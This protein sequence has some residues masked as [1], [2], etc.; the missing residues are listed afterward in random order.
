MTTGVSI[1]GGS[2]L[3]ARG[4]GR[5]YQLLL[6]PDFVAA[7]GSQHQ[8]LN[9]VTPQ[10]DQP[11]T[12]LTYVDNRGQRL[13]VVYSS[14]TLV[15]A[16][17]AGPGTAHDEHGRPLVLVFGFVAE[18]EPIS[19][20]DDADL[21]RAW[22]EAIGVYRAFLADEARFT[23]V[24][25]ASRPLRSHGRPTTRPTPRP[26]VRPLWI[27]AGVPAVVVVVVIVVAA[28]A[29]LRPSGPTTVQVSDAGT[30]AYLTSAPCLSSE[31]ARIAD[32][33][34]QSVTVICQVK[35][36][37]VTDSPVAAAADPRGTTKPVS[38]T[39]WYGVNWAG[40]T[41]AY[42]PEAWVVPNQRGGHRLPDCAPPTAAVRPSTG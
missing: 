38:S 30:G 21:T 26:P 4:R 42:L 10:P 35:G 1:Q 36:D 13:T 24:Q 15:P 11:P 20:L 39:R 9:S 18:A 22:D 5:G 27:T 23:P 33:G 40:E 29:L 41:T 2:F 34:G 12:Q 31:C 14:R 25:S 28:L 3:L 8:L 16:D 6:I 7:A 19:T 32:V 17:L 37:P